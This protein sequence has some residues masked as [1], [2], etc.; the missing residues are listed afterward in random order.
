MAHRDH[1]FEELGFVPRHVGRICSQPLTIEVAQ[2]LLRKVHG[3]PFL[4]VVECGSRARSGP[5]NGGMER[6]AEIDIARLAA[7][8]RWTHAPVCLQNERV[9][10]RRIDNEF[11]EEETRNAQVL[12]EY[13]SSVAQ[14]L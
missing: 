12:Y 6:G 1:C 2:P 14:C 5:V 10:G 8:C 3:N 4:A 13:D 7:M 9:A 11:G